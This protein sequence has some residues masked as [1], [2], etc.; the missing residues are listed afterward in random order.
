M[1]SLDSTAAI[2]R[3]V[4][5]LFESQLDFLSRIV[6]CQSLRGQESDV[7]K[8][9]ERELAAKGWDL[10]RI[11]TIAD[12]DDPRFSPGAIDYRGSWNLLATRG[13][14][15]N[16]R[17]LIL[18]AHVDVVP[19]GP[20]ED[21]GDEPFSAKIDDGWLYGRGAGD[22]KAGMSAIVYAMEAIKRAG[23][24]PTG[25]VQIH[26]VINE[27]LTGNGAAS[28]LAAGLT[29]DAV[30]IPEPT[31]EQLVRA[32]SGVIKFR[33]TVRGRP[34]HPREPERGSSA[35]DL[36]IRLATRLKELEAD[37]IAEKIEHPGFEK[38]ENPV[39]LTIG[40]IAGGE[41]IASLP[42][43]CIMEGRVGFY[44][45]DCVSVRRKMF[46]Q[47]IQEVWRSDPG[48]FNGPEPKVE[49][50]GVCQAGY[51]LEM[52]GSAEN[53]LGNAHLVARRSPTSLPDYVMTCYLDSALYANHGGIP[54]L[55][56]GPVAE[57]IHG[58]DE[59]VNID[60]LKRVTKTIALFIV[61]WCGS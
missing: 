34:A 49:W 57:N 51:Q 24:K 11:P 4:D 60:S 61:A 19:T 42:S 23:I 29:A 12:P 15:G 41:W 59:R 2:L 36:A 10:R 35:I 53:V 44:P 32:N 5:E 14:E 38:I 13:Q 25:T 21:W 8:L 39:A 20:A 28:M 9:I 40:T 37:W 56:Y 52:S 31:D 46:E 22:M 7:Q 45:G 33:L 43:R 54:S 6:R 18:N 26:S 48:F 47:F 55:V 58:I 3:S 17:S 27:E 16:G 1:T 50:V 30:L